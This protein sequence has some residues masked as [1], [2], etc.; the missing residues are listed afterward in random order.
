MMPLLSLAEELEN[1]VL[2]CEPSAH[3]VSKYGG[4][5]FTLYPEEKEAQFC[6]VFVRKN[7]VQLSF[8]QGAKLSHSETLLNGSGKYRR[9]I[10][11]KPGDKVDRMQIRKLLVEASQQVNI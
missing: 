7:H 2:D 9:H 8:S 5:L 6:G 1:L 11:F 3:K 10:N 4:T